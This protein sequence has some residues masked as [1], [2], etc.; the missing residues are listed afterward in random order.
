MRASLKAVALVLA[1]AFAGAPLAL[2][3]CVASCEAKAAGVGSST[4]ACHHGEAAAISRLDP[5][6]QPC[7]H[8]HSAATTIR[9]DGNQAAQPTMSLVALTVNALP[10]NPRTTVSVDDAAASPPPRPSGV[11]LAVPLRI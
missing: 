7:G 3:Q 2:D 4:P 8:D 10:F 6:P 1:I 11:A 9:A 5:S